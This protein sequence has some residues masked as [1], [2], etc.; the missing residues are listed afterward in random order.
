VPCG[1]TVYYLWGECRWEDNKEEQLVIE[2]DIL[3]LYNGTAI[4]LK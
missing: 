1:E 4:I 2:K 3:F